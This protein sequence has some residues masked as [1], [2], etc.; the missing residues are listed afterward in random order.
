MSSAAAEWY[1][2]TFNMRQNSLILWELRDK[3]FDSTTNHGILAHQHD[4]LP[5]ERMSD[6]K[7]AT[8]IGLGHKRPPSSLNRSPGSSFC[9]QSAPCSLAQKSERCPFRLAVAQPR[10][11]SRTTSASDR[12]ISWPIPRP[13]PLSSLITS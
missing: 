5:S 12:R 13:D 4:R 1:N 11:V 7:V 10:P 3:A 2:L 6:L 8:H 9:H